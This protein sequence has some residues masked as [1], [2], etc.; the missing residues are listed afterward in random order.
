MNNILNKIICKIKGHKWLEYYKKHGSSLLHDYFDNVCERC[1]KRYWD[2]DIDCFLFCGGA[3]RF[4][5]M[6][7]PYVTKEYWEKVKKEFPEVE[8]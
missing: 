2:S 6:N 4:W 1:G 7:K 5:E 8:I 3:K